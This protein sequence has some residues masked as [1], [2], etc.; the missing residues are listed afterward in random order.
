ML[1][2]ESN[3]FDWFTT[4]THQEGLKMKKRKYLTFC[5]FVFSL[6]TD[7][8][9]FTCRKTGHISTAVV[10]EYFSLWAENSSEGRTFAPPGGA[11]KPETNKVFIDLH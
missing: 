5:L 8:S 9:I 4:Q 11:K 10:K 2:N 6:S 7:L 1:N 3:C